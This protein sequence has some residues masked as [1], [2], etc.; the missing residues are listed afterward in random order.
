[1]RFPVVTALCLAL[2]VSACARKETAAV[3]EARGPYQ[4]VVIHTPGVTGANCVVQ[5]GAK[6]YTV[7]A[8]GSVMVHR[9]PDAM[10]VSCFKGDHMRGASTVRPT[11]APREAEGAR[12]TRSACLTC[13]YPNTVTVAMSLN[14]GSMDVPYRMFH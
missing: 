12:E 4:S 6:T 7:V 10:T 11:F 9:A 14:A 2:C 3:P 5:S 8:P 13:S 1:M